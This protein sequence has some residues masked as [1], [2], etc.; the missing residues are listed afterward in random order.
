MLKNATHRCF[1]K[2]FSD[3]YSEKIKI[4]KQICNESKGENN[5]RDAIGMIF[6][7]D[8]FF[9]SSDAWNCVFSC[10]T[11]QW[12]I[13]FVFCHNLMQPMM[14]YL[15]FLQR[16]DIPSSLC[17]HFNTQLNMICKKWEFFFA[18]SFRPFRHRLLSKSHIWR[19]FFFPN[20]MQDS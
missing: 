9:F 4:W 10:Y 19:H 17:M 15:D 11:G 5:K 13:T 1:S 3:F 7:F 6:R 14:I 18:S 20:R 8:F 2:P 12:C 16:M